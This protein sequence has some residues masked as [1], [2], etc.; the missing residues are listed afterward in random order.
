M[1][2]V[3]RSY[4]KETFMKGVEG[5][6][7]P[8]CTEWM[9]EC[10]NILFSLSAWVCSEYCLTWNGEM[11]Q[12]RRKNFR[13]SESDSQHSRVRFSSF[14]SFSPCPGFY[15]SGKDISLSSPDSLVLY[16]SLCFFCCCC[17]VSHAERNKQCALSHPVPRNSI[18]QDSVVKRS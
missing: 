7:P 18:S 16:F 1:G 15:A 8:S 4:C 11:F 9:T 14:F 2:G 10:V 12:L 3:G 17:S 5:L 13:A 6:W